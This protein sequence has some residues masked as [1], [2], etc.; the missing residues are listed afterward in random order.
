MA[1]TA[2]QNP[3]PNANPDAMVT[4]EHPPQEPTQQQTQEA[5]QSQQ[6]VDDH[7]WGVMMPCNPNLRRVDL[8]KV[9]PTYRIGR[10]SE[11]TRPDSNDIILP[12]MK[13][14]EYC[15]FELWRTV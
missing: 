6:A 1:A 11:T 14:S 7:L 2:P 8:L 15:L 4:D 9:R 13:I 12:G 3:G 10:N 5:S